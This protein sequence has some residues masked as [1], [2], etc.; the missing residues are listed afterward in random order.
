MLGTGARTSLRVFQKNL[1]FRRK[2]VLLSNMVHS[3]LVSSLAL[4]AA[5]SIPCI[6]MVSI[7]AVRH[8]PNEKQSLDEPL[9]LQAKKSK[10]HVAKDNDDLPSP[11]VSSFQNIS[12]NLNMGVTNLIQEARRDEGQEGNPDA[13]ALKLRMEEND[14]DGPSLDYI[15][16]IDGMGLKA[17][18]KCS[19]IRF[20]NH[21][22]IPFSI[23]FYETWDPLKPISMEVARMVLDKNRYFKDEKFGGLQGETALV[24]QGKE[25]WFATW[26]RLI[27]IQNIPFRSVARMEAW[28]RSCNGKKY[29][30]VVTAD[31]QKQEFTVK[32]GGTTSNNQRYDFYDVHHK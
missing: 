32:E 13:P 25:V 10:N 23:S 12:G 15:Q 20:F 17:T 2:S 14:W 5:L 28:G 3:A 30:I 29:T 16:Y 8:H 18:P 4:A 31:G 7:G 21:A 26:T 24:P 6:F 1:N 27:P 11:E 22:S 9:H 19:L